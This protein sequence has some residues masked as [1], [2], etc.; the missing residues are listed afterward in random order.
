MIMSEIYSCLYGLYELIL[1][2]KLI[3]Y[4]KIKGF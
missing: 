4:L 2:R 1:E 3:F